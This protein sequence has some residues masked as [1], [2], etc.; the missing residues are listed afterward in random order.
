M[1]KELENISLRN[2]SYSYSPGNYIVRDLT[3]DLDVGSRMCI[4]GRNGTGK[5]TLLKIIGLNLMPE[6]GK[7][8]VNNKNVYNEDIQ[9]IQEFKKKYIAFSFQEPLL[10]NSISLRENL[11]LSMYVKGIKMD[12]ED[13]LL[14]DALSMLGLKDKLDV[15]A[16]KLSGGERKRADILR[17]FICRPCVLILDE[18]M[19]H[20][21]EKSKENVLQLILYSDHIPYIIY[22]TPSDRDL[23]EISTITLNLGG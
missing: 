20:L 19:A 3:L 22:S 5:T 4:T 23:M 15:K 17:A 8:I 2:I 1:C 10:I 6:D 7:Y 11:L 9:F 18:P 13:P 21:D 16:G 14:Q 12:M